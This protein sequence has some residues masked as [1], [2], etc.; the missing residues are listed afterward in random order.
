MSIIK[1]NPE[2]TYPL[3]QKILRPGRPLATCFFQGDEQAKHF[4]YTIDNTLVGI[5]SLYEE[6][7]PGQEVKGGWRIRGVAVD[8][9]FR[10]R[11]IAS[12]LLNIAQDVVISEQGHFLWCNARVNVSSLYLEH[13]FFIDGDK[14]AIEGV[15]EHFR[16]IKTLDPDDRHCPN[17][18]E[19]NNE[20]LS[21]F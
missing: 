4:G 17:N 13:G 12:A 5:L 7:I 21:K 16:M 18:E 2:Q 6:D 11:G 1:I 20:P 15:G 3:R 10:R 19:L 8:Q 14:F 9:E